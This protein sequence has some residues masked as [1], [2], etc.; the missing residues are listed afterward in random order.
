MHS[1]LSRREWMMGT[2]GLG[3]S[4]QVAGTTRPNILWLMADEHRADAMRCAG[5]PMVS[6]PNLDRIASE[7]VR[8]SNAYTVCPVCSPS[9]ASAFSGRYAHVH[10]VTTNQVAAKNGEIFLPSILKHYGYHTAISGKLH[11]VPARYDFGFDQFWSFSSEGPTPEIGYNAFLKKKY[12]SP[13]KFPRVDGSCPWPDDPLG[14]DVGLFAHQPQDF[15]TEWIADRSIEYLRSRKASAQPWFLYTSFLRPHS[16]SVLPKKYFDMYDPA[17]V[18]VFPLPSYAHE[19]RAA[20][21]TEGDRRHTIEE[22][23]ME[24]VMTAKYLGA[25]TNVDDNIGRIL[26]EL[27]RLGMMDNTII[28]FSADHGNMLGEKGKWFKDLQYDGSAKVPLLWRGVKGAPENTGRVE[29]KV[30]ENTDILPSLLESL[31][32]PVPER[33]QG[34]SFLKLARGKDSAWKDRCFSQLHKGMYRAG[35]WKLIDNSLD[36]TGKLELY[37]LR[38]DPREEKNL[39]AEPGQHDRVTAMKKELT[40]YRAESPAPVRIAG[41]ALPAYATV[42]D[43]ERKELWDSAPGNAGK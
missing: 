2:A 27:E 33:V 9:R 43:A 42:S 5:H 4:A 32:L 6:T 36:L 24:R 22:P 26:G 18:P 25:V 39:A 1:S 28:L 11:F 14:R 30:V 3:M 8:F 12:G 17:K 38:N 31:N 19:Q 23:E 7:G 41:M 40:R 16:P 10:G 37:D 20:A 15:E 34:K 13:A 35:Q 29:S 21:K